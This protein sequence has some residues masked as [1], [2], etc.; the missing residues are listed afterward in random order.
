MTTPSTIGLPGQ[1]I[2]TWFKNA[3]MTGF[4]FFICW[5]G[6]ISYWRLNRSAPDLH[7]IALHLLAA[8]AAL[9]L[10]V[11]AGG[12]WLLP[13]LVAAGSAASAPPRE[14]AAFSSSAAPRA[15]LAVLATA[16]RSPHGAAA[17]E[18]APPIAAGKARAGL[19]PALLDDGFPA[20]RARSSYARMEALREDIAT[21]LAS[22]GL[23][24]FLFS[25]AQWRALTLASAATSDLAMV[26]SA[27]LMAVEGAAPPLW[28]VP[29]L[30]LEW[31][32]AQRRAAALWLEHLLARFG[33]PAARPALA[34]Q[35]GIEELPAPLFTGSGSGCGADMAPVT[36]MLVA[37]GSQTGRDGIDRRDFDHV[38]SAAARPFDTIPGESAAGLL[39]TLAARVLEQAGVVP[40]EIA[41]IVADT[42]HAG[43]RKLEL[44]AFASSMLPQLDA[45]ADIAHVGNAVGACGA[46]PFVTALALAYRHAR[47][48]MVPV[49]CVSNE[50]PYR[51]CVA[52]LRPPSPLQ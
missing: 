40:S 17:G 38:L 25:E 8:P 27:S 29:V 43:S 48:R 30:P 37:C 14:Q 2:P 46:V 3:L 51:R 19:D 42:G 5:G 4:V 24:E 23:D 33:W 6:M 7:E 9:A 10:C 50:D 35:D 36:A 31:R 20:M 16:M 49:L 47:E 18:L 26:A 32:A 41:M 11:W 45:T 1:Q 34:E 28:L 13:R 21:W 44:A 12:K 39:G 15:A 22:Q 52:L